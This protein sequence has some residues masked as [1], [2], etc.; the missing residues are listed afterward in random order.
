MVAILIARPL[1]RSR[2]HR[3]SFGMFSFCYQVQG[4]GVF[5]AIAWGQEAEK[6]HCAFRRVFDFNFVLA[7]FSFFSVSFGRFFESFLLVLFAD[8]FFDKIDPRVFFQSECQGK[9]MYSMF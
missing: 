7:V 6:K 4:L 3:I 8:K 9:S 1:P 2:F 5:S